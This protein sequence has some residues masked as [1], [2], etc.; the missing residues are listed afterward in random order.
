[1]RE[2]GEGDWGGGG[3]RRAGL[4]WPSGGGWEV[5]GWVTGERQVWRGEE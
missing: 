3:G 1:M 2:C 4:G 5:V